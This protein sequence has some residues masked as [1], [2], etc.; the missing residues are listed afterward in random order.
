M[1]TIKEC[2]NNLANLLAEHDEVVKIYRDIS[3]GVYLNKMNTKNNESL[4]SIDSIESDGQISYDA[5]SSVVKNS[6]FVM[7]KTYENGDSVRE[8]ILSNIA[9]IMS[10][11]GFGYLQSKLLSKADFET[12]D[13]LVSQNGIVK[14]NLED[15]V[16]RDT[17]GSYVIVPEVVSK[18]KCLVRKDV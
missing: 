16:I 15:F 2:Y 17:E 1:K 18:N 5:N 11:E 6:S 14:G 7:I 9:I 8:P 4:S 12:F 10:N 3:D 13:K